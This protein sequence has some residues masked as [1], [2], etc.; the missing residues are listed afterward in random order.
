MPPKPAAPA[1]AAAPAEPERPLT[2][3][4]KRA[5]FLKKLPELKAAGDAAAVKEIVEGMKAHEA[6]VQIQVIA[7]RQL[8][9]LAGMKDRA[10]AAEKRDLIRKVAGVEQILKALGAHGASEELHREAFSGLCHLTNSHNLKVVEKMG[11]LGAIEP[12]LAGMQAFM[13]DLELQKLACL[14]VHNLA[15]VSHNANKIAAAGGIERV[16]T[17]MELHLNLDVQ[18]NGCGALQVLSI[19]ADNRSRIVAAGGVERMVSAMIKFHDSVVVAELC[20]GA[21]LN[22][23]CATP[24]MKSKLVATRGVQGVKAALHKVMEHPEAAA[25]TRVHGKLILDGLALNGGG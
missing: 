15:H 1:A 17:A 6:I 25:N 2:V 13:S 14:A 3:E 22:V 18:L 5:L 19:S 10:A 21:L 11:E 12:I 9:G 23:G 4:E 20:C 8:A 7:C 16:T 24:Q